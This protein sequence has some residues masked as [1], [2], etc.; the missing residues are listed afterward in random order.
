MVHELLGSLEEMVSI[1][2]LSA[3]EG[4][5]IRCVCVLSWNP[6][7]TCGASESDF[8][9]V[10]SQGPGGSP[11]YVLKRTAFETDIVR[12]LTDDVECRE[13]LLWQHGVFDQLRRRS[14]ARP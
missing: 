6:E 9:K 8:L 3:L 14:R 12:Q 5:A 2:I 4:R 10:E 7:P 1:E 11:H 13:R